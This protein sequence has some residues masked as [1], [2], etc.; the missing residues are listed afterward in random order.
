[1]D[2]L[3][4][5]LE[6]AAEGSRELDARIAEEVV[7][8]KGR[9]DSLRSAGIDFY[10]TAQ[11]MCQRYTTSLDAALTLVPEGWDWEIADYGGDQDSPRAVLWHGIPAEHVDDV[12]HHG[13][14]GWTPAL[15]LCIASLKA[16][17]GAAG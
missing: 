14:F 17:R 12:K 10:E 16:R 15:A 7:W 6:S 3:I 9:G 13:A 5:D 2:A 8:V 1:M 11:A 4:A